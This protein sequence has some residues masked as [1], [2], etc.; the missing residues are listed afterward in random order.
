MKHTLKAIAMLAVLVVAG[1]AQAGYVWEYAEGKECKLSGDMRL[2]LT[3]FDNDAFPGGFNGPGSEAPLEYARLRTRIMACF[4]L[5]DESSLTLRIGNRMHRVSSSAN[6]PNNQHDSAGA[7]G[8]MKPS[9]TWNAPDEVFIDNL[10]LDLANV[11]DTGIALRIGRQDVILGSGLVLLEGTPYDQGRSIYFD[12]I[13]AKYET[14]SDTIRALALYN[15]YLDQSVVIGDQ[16]RPLRRGDT[17]VLGLDWT[18][19][20]ADDF[21][22][23]LY[24][25]FIDIE[26]H[27]ETTP[28]GPGVAAD[29]NAELEIV[30]LRLMGTLN[31]Q[32]DGSI[33]V[34]QQFGKRGD[35]T[36]GAD[37]EFT[38][39][40]LDARINLKAGGDV[41]F[42]PVLT[43]EYTYLS[44]DDRN[45]AD[46]NEGWHPAL[47]EYPIWRDELLPLKTWGNWTNWNQ[48]R[49]QLGLQL[50]EN[51]RLTSSYAMILINRH[52]AATA[53]KG[54]KHLGNLMSAFLDWNVNKSL[55][56]SLEASFFMSGDY[57]PAA[58]DDNCERLSLQ[59][60]YTF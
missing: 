14:E 17:S 35:M 23:E 9:G 36:A 42:N 3:H 39:R 53:A 15:D 24:Y 26:D 51:V 6:D 12:G 58:D 57:M 43:L 60:V 54:S 46:E 5:G 1:A 13:T 59:T 52:T 30:G 18:H 44:G 33:E 20:F 21:A 32:V 49:A 37:Q 25:L 2:R 38:G 47:A 56:V 28:S 8:N 16:S 40:M 29:G 55:K 31:E 45:S 10:Y 4:A 41:I 48:Y 7:T 27:D 50:S 11:A 34:A 22:A 19:R